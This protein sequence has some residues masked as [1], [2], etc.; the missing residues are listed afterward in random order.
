[1]KVIAKLDL[2]RGI[3]LLNIVSL[4]SRKVSRGQAAARFIKRASDMLK[5]I[6]DLLALSPD[7]HNDMF[8]SPI[9][10]RVL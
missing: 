5:P 8:P 7:K 2:S 10:Q 4:A 3:G 6:H 9:W 1:M